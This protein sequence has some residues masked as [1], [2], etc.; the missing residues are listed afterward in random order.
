MKRW[1]YLLLL[2]CLP[3]GAATH[4]IR[5]GATNENKWSLSITTSNSPQDF[6]VAFSDPSSFTVEWGNNVTNTYTYSGYQTNT[7]TYAVAGPYTIK[8]YGHV[9]WIDFFISPNPGTGTP[10][11]ISKINNPI[12]GIDGLISASCIFKHGWNI[13]YIP[14]N[15]FDACPSIATF[16]DTFISC[17]NVPVIPTGLFDRQTN[18]TGFYGTFSDCHSLTNIPAGLFDKATNN[19]NFS[20]TFVQCNNLLSIPDHLFDKNTKVT[21]F[22]GCFDICPALT[23]I[24]PLLF[25]KNTNVT[26]YWRVFYHDYAL[27]GNTPTN[28]LGQ[29][30]WELP[31]TPDGTECFNGDTGLDDYASIPAE[32][33]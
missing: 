20:Y 22:A 26:T 30:L 14:T 1:L 23:N 25:D 29:H 15:L 12:T 6:I 21:T 24:P 8:M 19:L 5:A 31:S 18:V 27:D 28:S 17:S 10:Y 33:K 2:S 7:N 32:W 13:P 16:Y 4:Y 3:A 11:L 9:H